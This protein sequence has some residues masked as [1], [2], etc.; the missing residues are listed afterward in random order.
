MFSWRNSILKN[1]KHRVHV[2]SRSLVAESFR[3]GG[4]ATIASI[5]RS[6]R[7]ISSAIVQITSPQHSH[8]PA[9]ASRTLTIVSMN[10]DFSFNYWIMATYSMFLK[11]F[12][13]IFSLCEDCNQE[14]IPTQLSIRRKK[15]IK[16][17]FCWSALK[18]QA[19]RCTDGVHGC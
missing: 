3:A 2:W 8:S 13:H 5:S 1:I 17:T 15:E 7:A 12:S 4:D 16:W 9:G 11:Y 14:M 18:V 10:G 6:G 19:V